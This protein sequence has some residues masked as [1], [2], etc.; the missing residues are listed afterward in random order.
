MILVFGGSE[1][2]VLS[3]I[4]G[5]S[6]ENRPEKRAQNFGKKEFRF[7]MF[8]GTKS[9]WRSISGNPRENLSDFYG[10]FKVIVCF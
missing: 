8:A 6:Q 3:K 10:S 1:G 4:P 5:K 7:S 2:E 9:R